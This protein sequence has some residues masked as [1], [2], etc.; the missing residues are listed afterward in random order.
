MVK[1]VNSVH[2]SCFQVVRSKIITRFKRQFCLHRLA[3]N[4][5]ENMSNQHIHVSGVAGGN[6]QRT[7]YL[8]GIVILSKV[9]TDSSSSA[10]IDSTCL[11]RRHKTMNDRKL[12]TVQVQINGV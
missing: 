9:H 6:K 7:H 1:K 12:Q 11:H 4:D 5:S 3:P 8:L 10:N 2:Y